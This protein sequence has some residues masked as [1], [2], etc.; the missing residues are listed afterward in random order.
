M[1]VLKGAG[2]LLGPSD[3]AGGPESPCQAT[4]PGSVC[5]MPATAPV[6]PVPCLQDPSRSLAGQPPVWLQSWLLPRDQDQAPPAP[7]HPAP[8]PG[9]AR[10]GWRAGLPGWPAAV[11]LRP[12]GCGLGATSCLLR[13][14]AGISRTNRTNRSL[15][16][17]PQPTSRP[18]RGGELPLAVST[19]TPLLS[20]HHQWGRSRMGGRTAAATCG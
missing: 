10:Q 4:P 18:T 9:G 2:F 17:T 19:D 1:T 15:P 7:D 3:G 13:E 12:R 14:A 11:W 20:C 5:P 16:L 6:Q 8:G